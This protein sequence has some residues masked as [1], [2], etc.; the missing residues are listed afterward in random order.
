MSTTA[1]LREPRLG[2]NA[3]LVDVS[4]VVILW[5]ILVVDISSRVLVIGQ[6]ANDA[7]SYLL[8]LV[9]TIPF[10]VHRRLPVVALTLVLAALLIYAVLHY[11]AF[12]GVNAFALLFG[13]ALHTDRRRSLLAFVATL[14]VLMI[15]L[16]VQPVNATVVADWISNGLCVTVAWLLGDNW[17]LRRTRW[18]AIQERNQL[19]ERER[20]EQAR[21][22][23]TAERMRI[24]RELHDAVAHSMSVIAIQAGMGHHVIDTQ[25]DEAKM[26]L[27]AIEA[28][29]RNALVEMRRLL[30]VLRQEGDPSATLTPS[31]GMKDIPDLLA[32]AAGAK[33][34][35]DLVVDG[36]PRPLPPGLDLSGYRIV[37]EAL[38]NVIKHGGA[39]ARVTIGYT[40]D[41]LKIEVTDDG[42]GSHPERP[43]DARAPGAGQGL[44]GMRERVAVFGG[45]LDAGPSP[46]GGYHVSARLPIGAHAARPTTATR[47]RK[48]TP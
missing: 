8:L 9:M 43:D 33:V 26:A 18:A 36:V 27:A 34:S 40:S 22:V 5:A 39:N 32:H 10:L 25:P 29:S 42:N 37:Q 2:V 14:V 19:L 12:P 46:E 30:G 31:P 11:A 28:T 7:F 4:V 15:A 21:R 1:E 38:T 35:A 44:I 16:A 45:Q 41:E 20:E 6:Q 47:T 17:R 13:I 48:Q 23:V 24:A 3:R